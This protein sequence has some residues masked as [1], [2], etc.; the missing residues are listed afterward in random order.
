M[1]RKV[2]WHRDLDHDGRLQICH[3]SNGQI[4]N[5]RMRLLIIKNAQKGVHLLQLGKM[6][7]FS[8]RET[9]VIHIL[10]LCVLCI[11]SD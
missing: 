2:K 7:C 6:S 1:H 8:Q 4:P 3:H 10:D 9:S 5:Y 11:P